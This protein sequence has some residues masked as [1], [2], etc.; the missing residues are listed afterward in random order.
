MGSRE[1]KKLFGKQLG[2]PLPHQKREDPNKL[3]NDIYEESKKALER[4]PKFPSKF[5]GRL[6]GEIIV[7]RTLTRDHHAAILDLMLG[8]IQNRLSVKDPDSPLLLASYSSPFK[9]FLLEEGIDPEYGARNLRAVVERHVTYE[10]SQAIASGQLRMGD[11]IVFKI[12]GGKPV[13]KRKPRPRGIELPEF[14]IKSEEKKKNLEE[15][16]RKSFDLTPPKKKLP[17]KPSDPPNAQ[18]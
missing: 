15:L 4:D 10:I 1:I 6:R 18:P 12:E 11:K 7:F 8:D 16:V 9:H 2:F 13:L 5:I 14:E 3:D 17:L